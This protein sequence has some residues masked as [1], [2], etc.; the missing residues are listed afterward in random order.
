MTPGLDLLLQR[1]RE[2]TATP[3]DVRALTAELSRPEARAELRSDWFLEASLP[4]ALA[5]SAVRA[6]APR[7]SWVSRSGATLV[8]WL[9]L[10]APDEEASVPA[11]RLWARASFTALALGFVAASWLAWPRREEKAAEVQPDSEPAYL[12][13]IMLETQLPD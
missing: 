1:W 7:P 10:F 9:T 6:R 2:G 12:A 13:Q 8:R 4:Q 5:A 3:E 11:L